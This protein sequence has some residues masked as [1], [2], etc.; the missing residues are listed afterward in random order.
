MAGERIIEEPPSLESLDIYQAYANFV[1]RFPVLRPDEQLLAFRSFRRGKSLKDLAQE[2]LFAERLIDEKS[3]EKYINAF[4]ESSDIKNFI[5]NCNQRLLL[6]G[7]GRSPSADRRMQ[8]VQEG[9][10]V[11]LKAIEEYDPEREAVFSTY[12]LSFFSGKL[13]S[14]RDETSAGVKVGSQAYGRIRQIRELS[15]EIAQEKGEIPSVDELRDAIAEKYG[16][17]KRIIDSTFEIMASGVMNVLSADVPIGADDSDFTLADTIADLGP[18]VEDQ[19]IEKLDRNIDIERLKKALGMVSQRN[20]RA[21]EMK[22]IEGKTSEEIAAVLGVSRTR[23][24]Q[25]LRKTLTALGAKMQLVQTAEQNEKNARSIGEKVL[26]EEWGIDI[27]DPKF[28]P[29]RII[30]N[31]EP[32]YISPVLEDLI[33]EMRSVLQYGRAFFKQRYPTAFF[34][35]ETMT[36]QERLVFAGVRSLKDR[37]QLPVLCELWGMTEEEGERI[38]KDAEMKYYSFALD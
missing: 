20:R 17:S 11:M 8:L 9:S 18:S 10:I 24:W 35:D 38:Y 15:E 12:L 3:S 13:S 32:T 6:M 2:P 34:P 23:V 7:A 5:F 29:R 33:F 21:I 37:D 30:I 36:E 4:A 1:G 14:I 31:R 22:L 28:E 16:Y 19:V 25:I 26:P 27:N